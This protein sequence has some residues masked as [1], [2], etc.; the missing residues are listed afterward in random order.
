MNVGFVFSFTSFLI[1]VFVSLAKKSLF[2]LV[3]CPS[4]ILGKD[5]G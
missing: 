2:S 5:F 4:D 1:K 3:W